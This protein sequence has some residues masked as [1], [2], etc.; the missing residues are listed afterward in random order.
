MAKNI[1]FHAIAIT[2]ISTVIVVL[3]LLI[4]PKP[5][6]QATQP[7][8]RFVRISNATWGLSCNTQIDAIQQQRESTALKKDA[9]G[10]VIAQEPLKKV[11]VD[12][13]LAVVKTA[14]EGKQACEVPATDEVLGISLPDGC[15]RQL[16]VNYRCAELD[17]IVSVTIDQGR[18]LHIDCSDV[19]GAAPHQP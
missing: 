9:D 1:R 17:R 5:Q 12:N 10:K 7:T 11:A 6:E 18:S 19:S 8:D 15:Y 14:C 2:I 13:A 16:N 3:F 4:G